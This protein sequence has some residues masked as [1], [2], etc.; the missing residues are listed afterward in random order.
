MGIIFG[1]EKD[2]ARRMTK[3]RKEFKIILII[4]FCGTVHFFTEIFS[5]KSVVTAIDDFL[6]QHN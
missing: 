1:D 4:G 5:N 3:D 2:E 6:M